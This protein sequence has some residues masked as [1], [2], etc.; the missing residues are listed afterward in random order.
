MKK[1]SIGLAMLPV[2][3]VIAFLAFS[4]KS[5]TVPKTQSQSALP[6][7]TA[8]LSPT[9]LP[10]VH[11][12]SADWCPSCKEMKPVVAKLKS[13][14]AG[15]VEFKL[16]D[17]DTSDEGNKL[18]DKF[19]SEYIPTFIFANRDGTVAQVKVGVI[20]EPEFIAILNS[21]K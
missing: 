11:E 2:V 21:L 18:M 20:P 15:K 12:I 3:L 17:S 8:T 14:F 7:G 13:Q 1:I 9:A 16:Y 10:V 6:P 5:T 19:N 4:P